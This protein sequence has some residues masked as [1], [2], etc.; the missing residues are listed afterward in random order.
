MPTGQPSRPGHSPSVPREKTRSKSGTGSDRR[1]DSNRKEARTAYDGRPLPNFAQ[2]VSV[3]A[4]P[5]TD[6]S[7]NRLVL[8][9]IRAESERR[10]GAGAGA[11]S[12]GSL[13]NPRHDD[14]HE[15]QK[16]CGGGAGPDDGAEFVVAKDSPVLPEEEPGSHSRFRCERRIRRERT[17][18]QRVE[19][20]LI[21]PAS[22]RRPDWRIGV[23][24]SVTRFS[25]WWP[26]THSIRRSPGGMPTG[27]LRTRPPGRCHD[28]I[29]QTR[30][31]GRQPRSARPTGAPRRWCLLRCTSRC[32]RRRCAAPRARPTGRLHP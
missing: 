25:R 24:R 13:Q 2:A 8:D 18:V 10:G 22:R 17:E 27:E 31:P 9:I 11:R 20:A 16:K 4:G 21:W 1:V 19:D 5:G 26:N 12:P 14:H 28:P 23:P 29:P 7:R 3:L 15:V 30:A 6:R 32:A